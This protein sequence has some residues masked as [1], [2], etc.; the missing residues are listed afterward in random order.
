MDRRPF[1]PSPRRRSLARQTGLTAASP[2]VVGAAAAAATVALVMLTARAA[3]SRL[4]ASLAAACGSAV[5]SHAASAMLAPPSHAGAAHDVAGVLPS[6]A[7]AAHDVAG[8][9]PSDATAAL[10]APHDLA[11]A[12]LAVAVPLLAAAAIVAVLAHVAQTRSFWLPRR[13]IAGAPAIE[14]SAGR[15]VLELAAP[16]VIGAVAFGW[17]WLAAPRLAALFG[18][19]VAGAR[20]AGGAVVTLVTA[21]LVLAALDSLVRHGEL[22]SSLAMSAQDKREDDRLAAADP[23]WRAQR[24]ALS[25]APSI[26][27]AAVLLLG[28]GVAV[29]IA[30]HP[31][32]HPLPSRIAHGSG[33]R[34]T[35]LLGLARRHRIAVHRAPALAAALATSDGPVG[36][37]HWPA[38]SQVLA[39]VS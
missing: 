3:I 19:P 26:A 13:R 10:L 1:P 29:A 32:R 12:V 27:T 37:S 34:A 36:E 31:T 18:A 22:A 2:V 8:V 17:L 33:P 20:L 21:W 24:A 15:S 9:L 6:H 39:A 7:G 30:W 28:D 11:T 5:P 38:L 14:R 23:R 25:R 16:V 35:Q 4:A